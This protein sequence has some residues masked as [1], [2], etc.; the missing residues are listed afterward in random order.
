[1]CLIT[2]RMKAQTVVLDS[3]IAKS[4]EVL[5]DIS[6]QNNFPHLFD[7]IAK[8]KSNDSYIKHIY[9]GDFEGK[10]EIRMV[11]VKGV[12]I[13]DRAYLSK[14]TA[15]YDA[16]CTW[17]FYTQIGII[18]FMKDNPTLSPNTPDGQKS[19]F[20]FALGKARELAE[21]GYCQTLKVGLNNINGLSK[22][23]KDLNI[24]QATLD[25]MSDDIFV[26][27]IDIAKLKGCPVL[28]NTV[29][30][31]FNNTTPVSN[32]N[33]D[34]KEA[35]S[36]TEKIEAIP[37]DKILK[38]LRSDGDGFSQV[39]RYFSKRTPKDIN[40][41]DRMLA[42]II[43]KADGSVA[44]RL[45]LSRVQDIDPNNNYITILNAIVLADN[46]PYTINPQLS[47][48]KK[49]RNHSWID[50]S[51]TNNK[52][53]YDIIN[54]VIK[55]DKSQVRFTSG[56]IVRDF[57]VSSREKKALLEVITA[58]NAMGGKVYE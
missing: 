45:M 17:L 43:K 29:S 42:Y 22:S 46:V 13:I 41:V 33:T 48:I 58:Y 35:Q 6:I 21:N 55:S 50:V 25:F 23:A 44:L 39:T 18:H 1:M 30:T 3:L 7:A 56:P 38:E 57:T 10:G 32:N 2:L 27:S 51:C 53:Y 24:K 36:T 19:K 26:K 5:P 49:N 20:Y 9:Y 14:T 12:V 34:R 11:N 28:F 47:D 15:D 52:F 31:N 37:L 54:S 8:A 16:L 40:D 4:V